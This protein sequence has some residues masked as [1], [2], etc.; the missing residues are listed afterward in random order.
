M[1]EVAERKRGCAEKTA[2]CLKQDAQRLI[3]M[4]E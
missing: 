4:D 3:L 1:L 2:L